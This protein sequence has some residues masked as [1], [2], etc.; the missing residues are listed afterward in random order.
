MKREIKFRAWAY[1]ENM[2]NE[3]GYIQCHGDGSYHVFIED[4]AEWIDKECVIM[5][6]TG[7]KDKNDVDIYEGDIL[8]GSLIYP[9]SD[10]GVLPTMGIVEYSTGYASFGLKNESGVTFF[11]HHLIHDFEVI[12]NIYQNPELLN[13]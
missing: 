13:S 10:N 5:Q 6:F 9:S 1:S 7:L 11:E 4:A 12:G 2:I 3:G 8:K